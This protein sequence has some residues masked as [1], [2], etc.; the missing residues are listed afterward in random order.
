MPVMIEGTD[1]VV[2]VGPSNA[3]TLVGVVTSFSVEASTELT[4]RGPYIGDDTISK[5]RH[6]LLLENLQPFLFKF[7]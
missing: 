6:F 1:G 7:D 2:Q 4:P 5:T 3:L